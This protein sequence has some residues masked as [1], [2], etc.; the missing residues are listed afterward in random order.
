M[1]ALQFQIPPVPQFITIGHSTWQPGHI[2]LR[3][4]FEVFDMI[5][6]HKGTFFITEDDIPYEV[7][8]GEMLI[9]EAGKTHWGH[10]S[11]EEKTEIY[12]LHFIH[13]KPVTTIESKQIQWNAVIKKGTDDDLAPSEQYMFLPKM[14][15]TEL[16]PLIPT[17]QS[18]VTLHENF[19][20]IGALPLN[21]LLAQLLVMIQSTL[22]ELSAP[23]RAFQH[24]KSME[25]YLKDNL[26]Q[27]FDA[28]KIEDELQLNLDYLARCLKKHTG[29]SP[30][31]YLQFHRIEKA[32][33]LLLKTSHT[34]PMIAE[35]VG[36]T[37]YN[38]FIRLFRKQ[39]GLT[40]GV[41]RQNNQ[42]Y[43]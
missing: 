18:M 37:D 19:N 43:V 26:V 31:Q 9:L 30:V 22:L 24:S 23:S 12:W 10:R 7:K 40:P 33:A 17:L 15:Q 2:H 5:F 34:V 38:Y 1:Q 41:Y 4:N 6:I 11:S 29:M 21:S 35:Q 28:Q 39:V 3:R 27:P 20:L 25:H 14:L 16:S 42:S 8:A 32:K 13:P 36:I